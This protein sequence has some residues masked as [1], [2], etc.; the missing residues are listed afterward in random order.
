MFGTNK[1]AVVDKLL[2]RVIE[3]RCDTSIGSYCPTLSLAFRFP[4]RR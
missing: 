2:E 3:V 4:A 1:Q